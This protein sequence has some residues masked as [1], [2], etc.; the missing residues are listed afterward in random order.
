[1]VGCFLGTHLVLRGICSKRARVVKVRWPGRLFYSESW[2]F[3]FSPLSGLFEN[4]G[5]HCGTGTRGEF[6]VWKRREDEYSCVCWNLWVE[7]GRD[8][9]EP[10]GQICSSEKSHSV[11]HRTLKH[12]SEQSYGIKHPNKH[13][14]V[15][16][17]IQLC[18][19]ILSFPVCLHLE[20]RSMCMVTLLVMLSLWWFTIRF[21]PAHL[22]KPVIF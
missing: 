6:F 14:T 17:I 7:K 8:K 3:Y 4:H 9:S 15:L 1:M 11:W 13:I 10:P 22:H 2:S 5:F 18:L 19:W 20:N 12:F 21:P 16:K